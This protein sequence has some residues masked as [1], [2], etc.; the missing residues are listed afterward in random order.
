MAAPVAH[1]YDRRPT[2]NPGLILFGPGRQLPW[3]NQ[4]PR[5]KVKRNAQ[6]RAK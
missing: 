3:V 6:V 5:V 1:G 4:L 2:G